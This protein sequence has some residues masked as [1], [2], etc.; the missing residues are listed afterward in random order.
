K[1][2]GCESTFSAPQPV[3]SSSQWAACRERAGVS[4]RWSST[5]F[6]LSK[7]STRENVEREN[8]QRDQERSRPRERLP[9]VERTHRELEDDDGQ[10]RHRRVHIG[11]PELIV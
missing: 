11:A 8:R 4:L 5:H 3:C 1:S 2:R 10:V 9:I 7:Y 6:R